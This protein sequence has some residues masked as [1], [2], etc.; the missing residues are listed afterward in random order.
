MWPVRE[1]IC[2]VSVLI[3]KRRTNSAMT[4]KS[5]FLY[6]IKWTSL[7]SQKVFTTEIE[8]VVISKVN[9]CTICGVTHCRDAVIS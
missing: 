3:L 7:A 5:R 6:E 1:Q 4:G 8:S 2:V 9:K